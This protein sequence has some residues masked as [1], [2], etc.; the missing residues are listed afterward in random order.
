MATAIRA[1][2][3]ERYTALDNIEV[4]RT[5]LGH[6]F[7]PSREVH[8]SLDDN[9]MV[10][11]VPEPM[12]AFH[13]GGNDKIIPGIGMSNSEVGILAFSIEAYFYRLACTNGLIAKTAVSSRSSGISAEKAWTSFRKLC[14]R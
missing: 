7:D 1:V 8:Y 5:M 13:V 2:F 9:L 3:T 4:I 10:L 6:G 12:R 14:G 11:K